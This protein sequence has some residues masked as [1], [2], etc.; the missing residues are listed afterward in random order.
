MK[1]FFSKKWTCKPWQAGL[2]LVLSSLLIWLLLAFLS[3]NFDVTRFYLRQSFV[4]PTLLLLNVLPILVLNLVLFFITKRAV[5]SV[6][7]GGSI[8]LL[9]GYVNLV[10][11]MF[12]MEPFV[13]ADFRLVREMLHVITGY[14]LEYIFFAVG[15]V[16]LVAFLCVIAW[17]KW[18]P[19]RLRWLGQVIPL[20][21]L[22]LGSLLAFRGVYA[23]PDMPG[24]FSYP[25][26][27]K[28]ME[29]IGRGFVFS[30]IHDI[31]NLAVRTPEGYDRAVMHEKNQ[32][33]P[34]APDTVVRPHVIM[35]MSEAFSDIS[36]QGPFDFT[37]FR[38]P[39]E[40]YKQIVDEAVVAGHMTVD[41]S[42][43]GT[44]WSE[45]A[46]LTGISPM[47]L[48]GTNSPYDYI[49]AGVPSLVR[50]FAALDYFTQGLHPW[51]GW[52]YNRRNAWR[53]LGFDEFEFLEDT[54]DRAIHSKGP[55]ISEEAAFD[56]MLERLAY[57]LEHRPDT[58]LFQFTTTVQ[59]HGGYIRTYDPDMLQPA[60]FHTDLDLTEEE[61]DILTNYF[62]GVIDS[63]IQLGRLI[64]FVSPL[65]APVVVMYF[66]DHMPFL[67]NNN[68]LFNTMD[69]ARRGG[70]AQNLMSFF[71]LPYFIWANSAALEQTDIL[72]NLEH[73]AI[74][75]VANNYSL[76]FLPSMLMELL[77][78][79]TASPFFRFMIKLR[80]VLPVMNRYFYREADGEL[81]SD[82]AELASE[83]LELLQEFQH[84][85]YYL[86]FDDLRY[87]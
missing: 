48:S 36:E 19:A 80:P 30:F 75:P 57:H 74:D 53:H 54:W 52:F 71:E 37:G 63:D 61:I 21:V 12:R 60:I 16:L 29:Y 85:G 31:S 27:G 17:K 40:R 77:G 14:S 45:F 46:G 76:H 38:D 62:T 55:Y 9:M 1:R 41:V 70:T 28:D 8:A 35:I 68:V 10:K 18:E 72:Q 22:L 11:L 87:R 42:G 64:D 34:I 78:F 65:D 5:F 4:R 26:G 43:G 84:W 81:V 82:R 79:E 86:L 23:V 67:H 73:A 13:P 7:L 32:A 51:H 50:Q 66:S 33:E 83:T 24:R 56:V 59:N 39:L 69:I 15:F 49:R 44:A 6:L 20:V 3:P 25:Y 58:P 47:L 2:V